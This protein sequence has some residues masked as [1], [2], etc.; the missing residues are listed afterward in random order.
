MSEAGHTVN[1]LRPG[2]WPRRCG[3]VKRV[4]RLREFEGGR[5]DTVCKALAVSVDVQVDGETDRA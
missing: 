1:R 2:A 5:D 3:F 4:A